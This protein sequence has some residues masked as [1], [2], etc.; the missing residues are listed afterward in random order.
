M[1]LTRPVTIVASSFSLPNPRRYVMSNVWDGF[2][3]IDRYTR[4]Q[5]IEDGVLVQLSGPGY[6]GDSWIP[7]MVAELGYRIPVAMTATAFARYVELTPAAKRACNDIQGRLWDVLYML[8]LAIGRCP[9]GTD[10]VF[11]DVYCVVDRV[12]PQLVRLK[13]VCG[14]GDEGEPVLTIMFPEED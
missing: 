5:A 2:E 1:T 7:E 12:K 10:T 3:V 4:H 9:E 11:F 14:P 6:E 8:R 13:S